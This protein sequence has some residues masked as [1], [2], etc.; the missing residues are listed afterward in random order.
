MIHEN[1]NSAHHLEELVEKKSISPSPKFV[2][3]NGTRY[4]PTLF[5]APS[6][7]PCEFHHF[8]GH[9]YS[10]FGA[11]VGVELEFKIFLL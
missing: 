11:T 4:I 8:D 7:C 1:N 6:I 3:Q 9:I 10:I 5:L 2:H